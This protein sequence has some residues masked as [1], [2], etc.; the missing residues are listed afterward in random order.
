MVSNIPFGSAWA[1]GRHIKKMP[2]HESTVIDNVCGGNMVDCLDGIDKKMFIV[3]LLVREVLI[4][5]RMKCWFGCLKSA[6][7]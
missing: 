4:F 3:N 6:R 5:I 1:E 7:S 2:I